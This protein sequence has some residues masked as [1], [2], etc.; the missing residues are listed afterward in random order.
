MINDAQEIVERTRILAQRFIER[1]QELRY[2]GR[3]RDFAALDY[4]CGAA[5]A[6]EVSGDEPFASHLRTICLLV[7]A[8]RGFIGVSELAHIKDTTGRAA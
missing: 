7:V 2:K 4:F 6:A 3:K 1:S 5:V 8:I